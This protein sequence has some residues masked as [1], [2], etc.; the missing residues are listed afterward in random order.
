MIISDINY[1]QDIISPNVQG[2]NGWYTDFLSELEYL[3]TPLDDLTTHI[4]HSPNG[5]FASVISTTYQGGQGVTH[6]WNSDTKHWTTKHW[7]LS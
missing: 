2:G 3:L 7:N 5:H 4:P 1:L 6:S